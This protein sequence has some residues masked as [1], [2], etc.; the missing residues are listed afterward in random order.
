MNQQANGALGRSNARSFG[1][2]PYAVPFGVDV[3]FDV[4]DL[5][6]G[7]GPFDSSR[8]EHIAVVAALPELSRAIASRGHATKSNAPCI[9][10]A[11]KAIATTVTSDEPGRKQQSMNKTD[12][13][14]NARLKTSSGSCQRAASTNQSHQLD[15]SHRNDN[16]SS[17]YRGV[18]E[19]ANASTAS[20]RLEQ[21]QPKWGNNAKRSQKRRRPNEGE[22]S[23]NE[24]RDGAKRRDPDLSHCGETQRWP[25]RS[26]NGHV[27]HDMGVSW[28]DRRSEGR[29]Q[30]SGFQGTHNRDFAAQRG[31]RFAHHGKKSN[32]RGMWEARASDQARLE[33]EWSM[34][35]QEMDALSAAQAS[36]QRELDCQAV[37]LEVREREL[38]ERQRAS[39]ADYAEKEKALEIQKH[40]VEVTQQESQSEI[41]TAREELNRQRTEFEE[42]MTTKEREMK[43]LRMKQESD[44][45][46]K[47]NILQ[48]Q[49]EEFERQQSLWKG[50]ADTK[51]E[52][53]NRERQDHERVVGEFNQLR[54]HHLSMQAIRQADL[55]VRE[56]AQE[57]REKAWSEQMACDEATYAAK[58][59]EL[60]A[61]ATRYLD[62]HNELQR[63]KTALE[64]AQTQLH[65]K[66]QQWTLTKAQ[67]QKEVET[68]I[69]KIKSEQQARLK[70]LDAR[71]AAQASLQKE[72]NERAAALEKLR[73]HHNVPVDAAKSQSFKSA[74]KPR[75]DHPTSGGQ[76]DNPDRRS[77]AAPTRK[78]SQGSHFVLVD[79]DNDEGPPKAKRVNF[80]P[81]SSKRINPSLDAKPKPKPQPSGEYNF[82]LSEEA[83]KEMQERLFREAASKMRAQPRV[84]VT[85][86]PCDAMPVEITAP[87]FD[88][89]D[90]FPDHWTW[91]DPYAVLGLPSNSSLILVK[92]QFR[93]LARRYHPDKS[94]DAN[95]SAKFHSISTVYHK[96]IA[97]SST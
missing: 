24:N 51:T 85:T 57:S 41:Q 73:K 49:R 6:H 75:T 53:L 44:L 66:L 13:V 88:I 37:A 39:E 36:K 60:N 48:A 64:A 34:L 45:A 89:V 97:A 33:H 16:V 68:W 61:R 47:V 90:R 56:Q 4:V 91:K 38:Q 81:E 86:A 83:A 78:S 30:G 63:R 31:G 29:S 76:S 82:S 20:T 28:N 54:S 18:T 43:I 11:A 23:W 96:L 22:V 40:E 92:S 65:E 32:K 67:Q 17:G 87:I 77:S 59:H 80:P 25:E 46:D 27:V 26:E 74:P 55:E 2:I 93:R 94:L 8:E 1:P 58:V 21:T 10:R 71:A 50:E 35:R 52:A 15:S 9:V 12:T 72:L 84:R 69:E 62:E 3:S 42:M 19:C 95:T 14:S 79:S 5:V 70:E 7:D